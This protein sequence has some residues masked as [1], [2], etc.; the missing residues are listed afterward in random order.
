MSSLKDVL[1]Y[2][3]AIVLFILLGYFSNTLIGTKYSTDEIYKYLE[4]NPEQIEGF[5]KKAELILENNNKQVTKKL[6]NQLRPYLENTEFYIGNPKG[7]K[8]VIEFFDYNCGYCKRVF[9]DLMDLVSEDSNL[10]IVLV[11]LPV[12]GDS[13]IIASKAALAS[14]SQGKYF[15]MHQKLIGHQGKIDI[16]AIKSYASE[17][18]LDID[19]LIDD[20]NKAD[21]K[22]IE[23]NYIIADKLGINGTPTFLIGNEII[24]GALDKSSFKNL[25]LAN[26]N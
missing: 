20:I 18:E 22:Y 12:L 11:E 8:I 5:I 10:K 6:V 26:Y 4:N 13:S 3:F 23:E 19:L 9:S 2:F 14:H 24:P 7:T 17:L 1:L 21:T 16:N 15:Q 25:L